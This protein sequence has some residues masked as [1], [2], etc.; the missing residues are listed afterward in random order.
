MEFIAQFKAAKR[1]STPLVCIRT[2]DAKATR[3]NIR[4]ALGAKAKENPFLLWDANHGIRSLNEA[5]T[6]EVSHILNG[7]DASATA[8]FSSALLTLE[9]CTQKVTVYVDN[10]HLQWANREANVIQ[11]IWNLRDPYKANANMLV[12]LVAPG[13]ALPAELAND[14]MVMDEPLPT[15]TEIRKRITETHEFAKV[16][17]PS[18]AIMQRAVDALVGVPSF[19][20]E[21]STAMCLNITKNGEQRE[22]TL[23]LEELWEHKRQ[24]IAQTPGLSVYRG[25]ETLDDIGGLEQV[26]QYFRRVMEGR[27]APKA[28]IFIDEIEKAVA[29]AGTD[30]S[31]V[32]GEMHGCM[33]SWMQDSDVHG[34]LFVGIPGTSK[35]FL[36]KCGGNTYSRPTVI[37]DLPGM[38]G[39]IIG[40]SGAQ[41]RQAQK[42]CDAISDKRSVLI[43]TCNS[44]ESLSPELRA[45]FSD[46]F[47]FD[48][49]D[50]TERQGIWE[51]HR[52]KWNIPAS[53][54]NPKDEG[55]VGREIA[56]CCKKAYRLNITLAEAA[57]YI[58]PVTKSSAELIHNLRSRSNNKYLSASKPGLYHYNGAETAAGSYAA[59]KAM[60]ETRTGR[61]LNMEE[62]D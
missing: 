38:Q 43:A 4:E 25:T 50:A 54:P 21:Q 35:S 51:I 15:E 33:L 39:G 17:A 59:P 18:E 9:A 44:V 28:V 36:T 49:P 47:F 7:M 31:G 22:G 55:W 6:K 29:G 58:V 60:A 1:V 42:V 46:I 61:V 30:M 8:E 5:G 13:A 27:D 23:D 26:K 62:D 37:F 34:I 12:L 48:A 32:K 3:D 11:G 2:F 41:L 56:A 40:Q 10:A 24:V 53:E 52:A 16:S 57:S 20:A 14:V 45:R 19:A